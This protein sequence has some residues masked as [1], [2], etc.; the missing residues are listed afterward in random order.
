MPLDIVVRCIFPRSIDVH[1]GD[2]IMLP[3]TAVHGTYR[4]ACFSSNWIRSA[5]QVQG[6]EDPCVLDFSQT[7]KVLNMLHFFLSCC[8]GKCVLPDL[9]C[10]FYYLLPMYSLLILRPRYTGCWRKMEGRENVLFL[11]NMSEER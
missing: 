4:S 8:F 3:V 10:S 5:Q 6:R 2:S 7:G 11:S 1:V 9:I